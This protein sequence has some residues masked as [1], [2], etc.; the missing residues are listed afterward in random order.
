MK[1]TTVSYT[2]FVDYTSF[3]PISDTMWIITGTILT[4]GTV[5]SVIPQIVAIIKNRSS[6]GLNPVTLFFTNLNQYLILINIIT[7]H[8]QDFVGLPSQR[9]WYRAL[10]RLL[11]FINAFSLWFTYLPLIFLCQIFFDTSF[12]ANHDDRKMKLNRILAQALSGLMLIVA[13]ALFG[14][15]IV[16]VILYGITNEFALAFGKTLGSLA[17]VIVFIQYLPQMITTFKLKD[18]GSLSLLMLCIQAPG[19]LCNSLFLWIG[20]GDHWT[21]WISYMVAASEQFVLIGMIVFYKCRRRRYKFNSIE[22][23]LARNNIEE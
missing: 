3:F 13:N 12:R 16:S 4:I 6:Y 18:N 15:Y 2:S 19:G 22:L 10:S 21:T 8:P 17:I 5:I 9:P 7:L 1:I 14:I 20:Q 23:P 11:T